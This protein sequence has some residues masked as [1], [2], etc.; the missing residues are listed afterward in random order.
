MKRKFNSYFKILILI[1][2]IFSLSIGY[3]SWV[4][5]LDLNRPVSTVEEKIV[6]ELRKSDSTILK[7]TD[8]TNAIN[9]A[10]SNDSIYV[11]PGLKNDDKTIFE[12]SLRSCELKCDLYM[13][14]DVNNLANIQNREGNVSDFSDSSIDKVI[15]N[16]VTLITLEENCTLTINSGKTIYIG[17][18]LGA[19]NIGINGQTSGLYTE[20][21]LK[22]NSKIL[23]SGTIDCFGYIKE[24]DYEDNGSIIINSSGSTI[25]AP[26]VVYDFN[27]GSYTVLKCYS[28]TGLKICPFSIFDVPNI[29][30]RVRYEYNSYLSGYCD[31]YAGSKHN[32]TEGNIIGLFNSLISIKDMNSYIECKYFSNGNDFRCSYKSNPYCYNALDFYGNIEIGSLSLT[33]SV[34]GI[35]KTIYTSDAP[36]PISYKYRINVKQGQAYMPYKIK[37]LNGSILTISEGATAKFGSEASFYTH[38]WTDTKPVPYMIRSSTIESGFEKAKINVYGNLIFKSSSGGIYDV[39]SAGASLS[40]GS[41]VS[42]DPVEYDLDGNDIY[43]DT[44]SAIGKTGT[45]LSYNNLLSGYFYVGKLAN[46]NDYYWYVG[47]EVRGQI[48]YSKYMDGSYVGDLGTVSYDLTTNSEVLL[49]NSE[50]IDGYVFDKYTYI[51]LDGQEVNIN[52]NTINGS[53]IIPNVVIENGK[54]TIDIRLHYKK[55][56]KTTINYYGYDGVTLISSTIVING[57]STILLEKYDNYYTQDTYNESLEVLQKYEHLFIGWENI[58]D[59]NDIYGLDCENGFEY[60]V[61]ESENDLVL[62]LKA[63]YASE[64]NSIIKYYKVYINNNSVKYTS[65]IDTRRWVYGI[66]LIGVNNYKNEDVNLVNGKQDNG[67]SNSSFT[68]FVKEGTSIS[69]TLRQGY[70]GLFNKTSISMLVDGSTHTIGQTASNVTGN[71]T[72]TKATNISGKAN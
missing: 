58:S 40:L 9:D 17:G 8:L 51:D 70:D 52:G 21:A 33:V 65:S 34:N 35:S 45:E 42:I 23:N 16:R 60:N 69:I 6:C 50:N 25:K 41:G 30:C 37:F 71:V 3:A 53:I 68:Y 18:V 36:L 31:L 32:Y 15:N 22:K 10:A 46:E 5:G 72:I 2:A 29:K 28:L 27:G 1:L 19:Q 39:Y 43:G 66:L 11:Y 20:I 7:Y 24:Y 26:M 4:E 14:Y 54:Y 38:I 59:S 47:D 56:H 13:P 62:N 67:L 63:R 57:T 55:A 61:P 49:M 48:K 44:E 64:V 12:I